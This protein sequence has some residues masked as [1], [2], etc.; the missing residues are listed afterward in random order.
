MSR[1]LVKIVATTFPLENKVLEVYSYYLLCAI[2]RIGICTW[3]RPMVIGVRIP[4][5]ALVI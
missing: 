2:S 5:G 4:D 3:F 1:K